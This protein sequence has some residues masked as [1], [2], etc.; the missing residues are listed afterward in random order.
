MLDALAG[1]MAANRVMEIRRD[2]LPRPRLR[3]RIQDRPP[4]QGSRDRPLLAGDADVP[5]PLSAEVQQ[6]F[7]Q[8]RAAGPAAR[9]TRRC[10]GSPRRPPATDLP[11]PAPDPPPWPASSSPPTPSRGPSTRP[12]WRPRSPPGCERAA[13]RQS[14]ARS[15][16]A[17]RG[18]PGCCWRRGAASGARRRRATRWGAPSR[19]ASRCSATAAPR[20]SKRRLP[21]D[22]RSWRRAISMPSGPTPSGPAS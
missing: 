20:S 8:L 3:S 18:R 11:A 10:C 21:R 16:T 5:L 6:M 2:E 22:W 17:A 12:R 7:R 1:G 4:P 14:S 15:E 13:P 9:T 19:P